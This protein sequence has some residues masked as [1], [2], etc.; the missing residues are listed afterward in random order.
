MVQGQAWGTQQHAASAVPTCSQET[1][2]V[3]SGTTFCPLAV[4]SVEISKEEVASEL[5][6]A[7]VGRCTEVSDS[8][9]PVAR[10][11]L[12]GRVFWSLITA[13]LNAKQ[14]MCFQHEMWPLAF[15]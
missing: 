14:W 5:G 3:V 15:P 12:A 11:P 9:T 13:A 8:D 1:S 10:N 6:T 4:S 2:L 7:Q